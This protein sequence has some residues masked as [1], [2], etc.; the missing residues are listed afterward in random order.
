MTFTLT[1]GPGQGDKEYKNPSPELIDRAIN[2][3]LPVRNHFV[4][5]AGNEPVVGVRFLQV[6]LMNQE[7]HDLLYLVEL[8][9]ETGEAQFASGQRFSQYAYTTQ[10]VDE[11]ARL[12]RLFALGITPNLSQWTD[13]TQDV[14]RQI[15]ASQ[16]E[17]QNEQ[18]V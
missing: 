5:L 4:I 15:T 11:V 3:L 16:K 12:F 2:E 9:H 6:I 1:F 14:I 18:S 8:Q 7:N 10:N 13:I 17:R